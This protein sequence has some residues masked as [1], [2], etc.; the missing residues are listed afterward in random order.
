[1]KKIDITGNKYGRLT[2]VCENGKRGKNVLW[3]CRCDCGR[4]INAIAY[5]LKNGHTQS[6]GCL[7]KEARSLSHSTHKDSTSRLYRIW[8][9]IKS[10]CLNPNVRHY[11]YYGGRG[12]SICP[13]W[14]NS[15]ESFR[16]WALSNGYDPTLSIDRI[17]VNGN[18]ES[19]NCRWTNAKVQA[20]NKT[21][22]RLIEYNGEIRTL[23]EWS[24]ILGIAHITLSKRIDDYGWDV[25][26]AFETPL[27]RKIP[28]EII[29]CACGCGTMIERYSKNGRERRF[30][31]GHN[32]K[33]RPG[34]VGIE[35][36]GRGL[37]I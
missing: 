16:A 8:R 30:V 3:L 22:N 24:Q 28:H 6:C 34:Y 18:Y 23:S 10:R 9:H 21:S 5:N 4:E 35:S 32:N 27:R 20:N 11:Q 33:L 17:D 2:V 26:R 25:K 29:Q 37:R 36:V 15:Y 7:Q 19:G 31:V 13:E 12:I 1:M 14:E